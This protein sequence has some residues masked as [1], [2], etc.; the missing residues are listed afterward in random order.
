V[1]DTRCDCRSWPAW[2]TAR[3]ASVGAAAG[4]GGAG[5]WRPTL[6]RRDNDK[7]RP[8]AVVVVVVVDIAA[9]GG[10]CGPD[11]YDVPAAAVVA[12]ADTVT[13]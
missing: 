12:A 10:G 5:G 13:S 2:R 8:R 3:I 7:G 1:P 6:R 9:A 4:G 11:G